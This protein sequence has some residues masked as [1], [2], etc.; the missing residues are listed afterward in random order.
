VLL[1]GLYEGG[2]IMRQA[3][4]ESGP[5]WPVGIAD[6]ITVEL[7]N[8]TSYSSVEFLAT[9]VE[10]SIGGSA[11]ITI[12]SQYSGSY[13]ITIK[14]RNHIETVSAAPVSFTDAVITYSFNNRTQA[15]GGNLKEMEF[16][17]GYYALYGGDINHDGYVDSGDYP[18]VIND[19]FNYL[20]GYL[21]TDLNGDGWV[22]SGDYPIL[23]NNNYNY[24]TIIVPL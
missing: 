21:N 14:H 24:V 15:Y 3:M 5:Q 6:H 20:Y 17:S 18:S 4:G 11:T 16:G 2:G 10:L 9:D 19:S 8:S 22:D 23:V 1:E 7:H 12:P 13:Y